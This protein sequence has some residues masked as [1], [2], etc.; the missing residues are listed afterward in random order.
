MS[1]DRELSQQYNRSTL[2]T[3]S[4]LG[5]SGR[6]LRAYAHMRTHLLVAETRPDVRSGV[7]ESQ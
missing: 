3:R 6:F 4:E 5:D 2:R 7:L 1:H